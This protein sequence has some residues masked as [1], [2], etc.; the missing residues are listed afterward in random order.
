MYEP[1][2]LVI[3]VYTYGQEARAALHSNA[4]F[5][6]LAEKL[7]IM[8]VSNGVLQALTRRTFGQGTLA[9]NKSRPEVKATADLFETVIGAYYLDYGFEALYHWVEEI[10]TPLITAVVETFYAQ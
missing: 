3:I 5:S 4:T 8:A 7:D 2:C 10:Y 1:S 9:P 6:R